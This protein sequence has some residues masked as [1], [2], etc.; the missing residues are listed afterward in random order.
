MG[1]Q[2]FDSESGRRQLPSDLDP[3]EEE[4]LKAFDQWIHTA[5]PN[6]TREGCPEHSV[7]ISFAFGSGKVEDEGLLD[8][9][10]HC[11]A[12]LDDLQQIRRE[13]SA[14]EDGSD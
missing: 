7:L 3:G 13:Q 8:H 12:C 5:H 4:L 9:V 10:G 1:S 6:P 2:R 11:A 14:S